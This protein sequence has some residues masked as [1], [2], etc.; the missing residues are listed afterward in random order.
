MATTE[1]LPSF[2]HRTAA[3]KKGNGTTVRGLLQAS[4]E[5]AAHSLQVPPFQVTVRHAND[6]QNWLFVGPTPYKLS[7]GLSPFTV[8]PPTAVSAEAILRQESEFENMQDHATM[9]ETST[10]LTTTDARSLQSTNAYIP[11]DF[12]KL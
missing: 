3:W 8:T 6:V 12:D 4:V 1:E 10:A 2:W 5:Q 11:L 9:V 7:A